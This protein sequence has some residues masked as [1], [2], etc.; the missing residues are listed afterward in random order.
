MASLPV[1]EMMRMSVT[2]PATSERISVLK[3]S[4]VGRGVTVL[5]GEGVLV[6]VMVFVGVDVLVGVAVALAVAVGRR[7][8]VSFG[9]GVAMRMAWSM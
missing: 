8:G 7:V 9:V 4:I 3:R 2:I 1:I 5:V 6:G